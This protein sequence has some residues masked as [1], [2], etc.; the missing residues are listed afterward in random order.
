[1]QVFKKSSNKIYDRKIVCF[2]KNSKLAED[3]IKRK[4]KN[5][6]RIALYPQ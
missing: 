6:E 3:S 4:A 5:I 2:N 1:M